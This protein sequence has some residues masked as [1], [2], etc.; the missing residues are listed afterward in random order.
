M[1]I[2]KKVSKIYTSSGV[3]L[4]NS[5][6]VKDQID[7]EEIEAQGIPKICEQYDIDYDQ[8]N[9]KGAHIVYRRTS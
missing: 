5:E 6:K 3:N 4:D 9:I 1:N 2:H 7:V 8:L